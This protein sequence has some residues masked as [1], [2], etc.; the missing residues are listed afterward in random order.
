M[1]IELDPEEKIVMKFVRDAKSMP[2]LELASLTEI[3]D[4]KVSD[5]VERLKG[6]S[7]VTVVNQ[8]NVFEKLVTATDNAFLTNT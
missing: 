4:T 2:F 1:S 8:D 7:L 6:K 5:I 3:D